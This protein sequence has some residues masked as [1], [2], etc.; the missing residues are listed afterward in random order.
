M[1]GNKMNVIFYVFY[2]ER[3][4]KLKRR[5]KRGHKYYLGGKI[6]KKKRIKMGHKYYFGGLKC[7]FLRK[8]L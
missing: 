3:G 4:D 1:K 8:N 5:I 7:Y 6:N 2:V